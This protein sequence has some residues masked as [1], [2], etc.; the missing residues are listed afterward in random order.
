LTLKFEPGKR[1]IRV[2]KSPLEEGLIGRGVRAFD[3]LAA[4]PWNRLPQ[5]LQVAAER[6]RQV[7]LSGDLLL[8]PEAH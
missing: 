2:R 3:R 8:V 7:T 5:L 1:D 4:V 6:R